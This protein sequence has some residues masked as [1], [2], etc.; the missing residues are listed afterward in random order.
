MV[1]LKKNHKSKSKKAASEQNIEKDLLKE[2]ANEF[3]NIK[4]VDIGGDTELRRQIHALLAGHESGKLLN[5]KI[6]TQL[7]SLKNTLDNLE[8]HQV[9]TKTADKLKK[10]D[11]ELKKTTAKHMKSS[12]DLRFEV[13]KIKK[14]LKDKAFASKED[15][16]RLKQTTKDAFNQ[17]ES[18]FVKENKFNILDKKV[19]DI[20]LKID[21]IEEMLCEA[22]EVQAELNSKLE[23]NIE[24][25]DRIMEI[26]EVLSKK[27]VM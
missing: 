4:N 6:I 3:E 24:K 5:D 26:L 9:I 23:D 12:M 27:V 11:E 19:I 7:S 15:L 16:V 13:E 20:K 1:A 25:T 21:E 14:D 8:N 17:A 18:K 2:I 22:I 10:H